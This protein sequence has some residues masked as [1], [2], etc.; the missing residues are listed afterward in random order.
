MLNFLHFIV[1]AC[2]YI[3]AAI[4]SGM[5]FSNIWGYFIVPLGLPALSIPHAMGI[6]AVSGYFLLS[7]YARLEDIKPIEPS[8]NAFWY[9]V[10]HFFVTIN[11]AWGFSAIIQSFM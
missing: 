1:I 6:I 2:A 5:V 4:Y 8:F 9:K 10:L 3:G 7:V 11:I